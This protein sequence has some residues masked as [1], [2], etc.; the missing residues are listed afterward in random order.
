M[1]NIDYDSLKNEVVG[2][3][4]KNKVLVLATSAKYRV[5]ARPMSCVYKVIDIYFQTDIRFTKFQQIEENSNVAMSAGNI[6]IEGG[7]VIGKHPFDPVNSE[8]LEMY[9][10]YH[11]NSYKTYSHLK[12]NIVIKVVPDII[13]FWK[14]KDKKPF[15]DVLYI[16]EQKAVRDF[17]NISE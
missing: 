6:Q 15:R 17:Y 9:K 1:M 11:L 4:E 12:N 16:K 2:F 5:T 14:Y 7:A 13:T 3:F 8:F 10:K